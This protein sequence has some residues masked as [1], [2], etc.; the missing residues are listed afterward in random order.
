MNTTVLIV[1]DEETYCDVLAET[2]RFAGM[3]V[4]TA[5][6]A[7]EALG[8][9]KMIEPDVILLDIMLPLIDGMTLLRQLRNDPNIPPIPVVVI[10][11]HSVLE[12]K[13][14][15]FDAGA[16]GFLAKPFTAS[17]LEHAISEYLH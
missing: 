16:N 8:L 9:L 14:A 3:N 17:E 10:S 1:D 12:N 5:Y 11:A 15:A 13:Q 2:L 4:H 7:A 6:T